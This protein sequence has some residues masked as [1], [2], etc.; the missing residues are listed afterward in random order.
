[1]DGELTIPSIHIV[2]QRDSMVEASRSEALARRFDNPTILSHTGGHFAPQQWPCEEIVA[3][4][5]NL[6][7]GR[8][9]PPTLD[10]QVSRS[11]EVNLLT[12]QTSRPLENVALK[13]LSGL[14]ASDQLQLELCE[15]CAPVMALT[16]MSQ[17][18][19]LRVHR[20]T[21]DCDAIAQQLAVSE[22]LAAALSQHASDPNSPKLDRL[23]ADLFVL[24]WS[25]R[26]HPASEEQVETGYDVPPHVFFLWI[27]ELCVLAGTPAL[28]LIRLMPHIC[29]GGW[30]DLT[31]LGVLAEKY[32]A[33]EGCGS[34]YL[35]VRS[36]VVD[37]FVAQLKTDHTIAVC[38]LSGDF[39]AT[40]GGQIAISDAAAHAPRKRKH[41]PHPT[42]LAKS[43]SALMSER[44]QS[45][46][47]TKA[48][49]GTPRTAVPSAGYDY[50][51]YRTIL[52]TIK[53]AIKQRDPA[54]RK[55]LAANARKARHDQ[56]A[57][58]AAVAIASSSS[59][60]ADGDIGPLS[61]NVLRP[62]PEPVVACDETE[63][64]PLI[65]WMES[66]DALEATTEFDKGTFMKVDG[67]DGRLDLC[68]Q[69]VGPSNVEQLIASLASA[70]ASAS[71]IGT[72]MIGNNIVG[73]PGARA[74]AAAI[75]GKTTS[76]KT[77]YIAGNEFGLDDIAGICA[78]LG[79]DDLVRA[80][81]LKR[82]PLLPSGGE[83]I[84]MML[85]TNATLETLDLVNTGLLDRG[86]T[87]VFAGL[88]ESH[89]TLRH[90]YL[91]GN[92]ITA[93]GMQDICNQ[94]A[95]GAASG[96]ATLS[97]GA[98]RLCDQGAALLC[99]GLAEPGAAPRLERLCLASNRIGGSG[100]KQCVPSLSRL[101][102]LLKLDV[103]YL[104]MTAAIGEKPNFIEAEGVNAL[105][106]WLKTNPPL[107]ILDVSRNYL[108][109]E[110]LLE[111]FGNV[112]QQHNTNLTVLRPITRG[113]TPTNLAALD[114][115]RKALERNEA[116]MSEREQKM[117]QRVDLPEHIVD[118]LSV[119]R[120]A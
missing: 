23:I 52:S 37:I 61:D 93:H 10:S 112:L 46:S 90:L 117:A 29:G 101:P 88:A 48:S 67:Y 26:E 62:K 54:H 85:R 102:S 80:L 24:G 99:Q 89:H 35:P 73:T 17:W 105:A 114:P 70:T 4:L 30:R 14:Q 28:Q 84:S 77:W 57:H 119:Y 82:N 1:M 72:L 115:L 118:I 49:G 68:K 87:A 83:S 104:K 22:I 44:P 94:L 58:D 20:V 55:M 76:I 116:A 97:M 79:Y 100:V 106:G 56:E 11:T 38:E 47:I 103:G 64:A 98:N 91:D 36:T 113:G 5:R 19:E 45:I 21:T 31:R 43:I 7:L 71:Q 51:N 12:R 60:I 59:T 111:G 120:T 107:R 33:D 95:V 8:T 32:A 42:G 25:L 65:S 66:D 109:V 34:P 108:K 27:L 41:K 3:W 2:G 75:L 6:D 18:S 13:I 16:N 78:A 69:V 40:V 63:L 81:W 50:S 39:S 15:L 110:T 9:R 92:G 74:I 86:A 96:L 53:Q